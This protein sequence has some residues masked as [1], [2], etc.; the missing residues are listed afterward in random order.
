MRRLL[1]LL[2]LAAV[3]SAP[4]RADQVMNIFRHTD[5]MKMMG[6][7]TPAQDVMTETWFGEQGMRF[8]DP[9]S[10]IIVRVDQK[11]LFVV[12]K[13]EKSFSA[14]DLPFDFK[15]LVGPE[16]ASMMDQMM[17]M[18]AATVTVTPT[19]RSGEYAGYHCKWY[20]V[21]IKMNMMQ[22]AM[23][24]CNSE[25]MPVDVDRYHSLRKM[26]AEMSMNSQWIKDLMDKLP[27][28]AVRSETATTMMG[29]TFKSWQ[30]LRSVEEK[31]APHGFYEPPAGFKE[32]KFD[33]MKQQ[34]GSR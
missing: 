29:K 22:M 2:C 14:I 26:Q 32:I 25:N 19:D 27:G 20:K 7:T 15:S 18:M 12:N 16:M 5:E 28:F 10:A 21:D 17:K 6:H 33:P 11:K 23:D 8:D 31:G 34:Q 4:V 13:K 3:A 24:S 9:D 30:E 1:A